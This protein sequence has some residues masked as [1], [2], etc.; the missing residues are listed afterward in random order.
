MGEIAIHI[1]LGSVMDDVRADLT[2][3][4]A[5]LRAMG[6]DGVELPGPAVGLGPAEFRDAMVE[7]G[8]AAPSATVPWTALLDDPEVTFPYYHDR[9][10]KTCVLGWLDPSMLPGGAKEGEY[11][12]KIVKAAGILAGHGMELACH[13]HEHEFATGADGR[14]L[15]EGFLDSFPPEVMR[16]Q[17][18]LGWLDYG[19]ADAV[20]FME[21]YAGR[22]CGV[23]LKDYID[24][25]GPQREKVAEL[26]A[27][28]IFIEK[29]PGFL[30]QPVGY[31]QVDYPKI[32]EAV[33]RIG[34]GYVVVE[35]DRSLDR[36]PMEAAAMSV[37]YLRGKGLG[38]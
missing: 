24:D 5:R 30:F 11:R 27:Q 1:Q 18:D 26:R 29:R 28:G 15:M 36:T 22:R 34:Y 21:R 2:G 32:I 8:L 13:N 31:G 17:F 23:H 19:G 20:H 33:K 14:T 3:T 38:K 12:E 37:G 4:L 9:G 10:I 16:T 25:R 7:A 35:Q 6:Y